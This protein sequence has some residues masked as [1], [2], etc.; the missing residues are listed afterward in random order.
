MKVFIMAIPI[1]FC[2]LG[3]FSC[4]NYNYEYSYCFCEREFHST[5][6]KCERK[7]VFLLYPR[8]NLTNK[9][10]NKIN[11]NKKY[12]IITWTEPILVGQEPY[13]MIKSVNMDFFHPKKT[14]V[15]KIYIIKEIKPFSGQVDK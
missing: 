13:D 3:F 7:Y 1:V 6:L 5:L 8:F 9:V 10:Y 15:D 12:N 2:N 14:Q 4:E 11:S